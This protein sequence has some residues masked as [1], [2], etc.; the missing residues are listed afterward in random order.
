M[1]SVSQIAGG[2][3]AHVAGDFG[4]Q[5]QFT[6]KL[7]GAPYP[8]LQDF[9]IRLQIFDADQ[10]LLDLVA[11]HV[12][13]ANGIAG[14]QLTQVQSDALAAGTYR[15]RIR[16]EKAGFQHTHTRGTYQVLEA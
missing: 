11:A 7:N 8:A 5:L 1:S 10:V 16:L 14:Y 12:D 9:T 13:D 2:E 6:L 15:F 4:R 3:L